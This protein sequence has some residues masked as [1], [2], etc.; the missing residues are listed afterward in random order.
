MITIYARHYLTQ[1]GIDYVQN[2][3]FPKVYAVMSQQPGFVALT[4]DTQYDTDDCVHFT[5]Q[6]QNA[7]TLS[8]WS[9]V[10]EHDDLIFKLHAYRSRP[11]WQY[12]RMEGQPRDRA[13]L[14]WNNVSVTLP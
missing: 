14:E 11:Y 7:E 1:A 6:F 3:W 10:P 5:V 4:H 13:T 8:Q 9:K 2:D 12:I